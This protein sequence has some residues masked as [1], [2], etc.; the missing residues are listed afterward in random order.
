MQ[1][2]NCVSDSDKIF[3]IRIVKDRT[4]VLFWGPSSGPFLCE[5]RVR[6]SLQNAPGC[7]KSAKIWKINYQ[8][9]QQLIKI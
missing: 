9:Y 1:I 6:K 3:K 4:G 5:S 8:Q 7:G 2:E